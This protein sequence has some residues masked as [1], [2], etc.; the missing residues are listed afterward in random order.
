[1]TVAERRVGD[2]TILVLVGRLVFDDGDAVLRARITDLTTE[3][4]LK[5]V[6]DLRGVTSIDS[7]GVGELVA[8]LVSVRRRGGDI[9]LLLL[10]PR[11]HRVM[12]ISKLLDVFATFDSEGAALASFASDRET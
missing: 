5:I 10:S 12:D 7:C 2:V 3:G 6:L 8:R 1:M 11:A 9:R 4:R